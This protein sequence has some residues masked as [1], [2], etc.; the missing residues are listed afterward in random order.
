MRRVRYRKV[1]DLGG[2]SSF[3]M[4][5]HQMKSDGY[6]T[7]NFQRRNAFSLKY[8]YIASPK[9]IL[10]FFTSVVELKS[11]TPDTKVPTRA[12]IAKFGDNYLMVDDPTQANHY[13]YNFYHIPSDFDYIGITSNLGPWLDDRSEGLYVSLLQQAELQRSGEADD[14]ERGGQTE[15]LSQVRRSHPGDPDVP[16]WRLQDRS[17]VRVC[18]DRSLPDTIRSENLDRSGLAEL[19]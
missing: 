10:T 4:D 7:Y 9:T 14:V 17:V 19:P 5:V 16:A 12:N 3:M 8:Q 18:K 1:W 11:N 6:Q 2:K 15:Q 13:K